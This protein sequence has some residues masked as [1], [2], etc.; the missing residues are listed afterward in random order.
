MAWTILERLHSVRPVFDGSRRSLERAG[1][2][3]GDGGGGIGVV[4]KA[5]GKQHRIVEAAEPGPSGFPGI[6]ASFDPSSLQVDLGQC[7]GI[8]RWLSVEV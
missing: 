4:A 2:L 8:G 1:K 7:P 5:R 6:P 3:P